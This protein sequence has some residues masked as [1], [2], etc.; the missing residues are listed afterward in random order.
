MISTKEISQEIKTLEQE[1]QR[2]DQEQQRLEYQLLKAERVLNDK[3][4]LKQSIDNQT[5]VRLLGSLFSCLKYRQLISFE[6]PADVKM[7]IPVLV[8]SLKSSILG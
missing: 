5:E 1:K 7:E 4:Q 8:R 2:L 6:S 3:K